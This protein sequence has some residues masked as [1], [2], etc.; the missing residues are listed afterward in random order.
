MVVV[1]AVFRP[2][3]GHDFVRYDD[4]MNIVQNPHV[5]ELTAANLY[6]MFTDTSYTRYMPL[7]WM[8]YAVDRQLFGLN[9]HAFHAGNLFFHLLNTLLLFSLL[10][11]IVLRATN[12]SE[13]VATCCAALGALWW[14]VNPLR[15]EPV[16]WA[17]ARIYN[18]AIF[19]ALVWL[20][21][22][23]LS[24]SAAS[25]TKRRLLAW[26]S[27]AGFGASLLTY[28]L[29]L[30]AP[31]A[32]F[33]MDVFPLRRGP[34]Q[35]RGW[36]RREA[37]PLWQEKIPFFCVSFIALATTAFARMGANT[38][39]RTLSL[40]DFGLLERAMQSCYVFAY[41]VWKPWAPLDLAAAYPT[42]HAFDPLGWRF[43]SSAVF[44]AGVTGAAIARR[45]RW[46]ILLP[47]WITHLVLLVPFLGLSEYP[48]SAFDRYAHLHSLL[49]TTVIAAA[50]A[51][52][53]ERKRV[54]A[55]SL[56][57]M[58]VACVAF[59]LLA[60]NQVP[61]WKNPV[62]LYTRIVERFGEHPGRSRFDEVLGTIH[63]Q[64]RRTNDAVA[65][66]ERAV[67]YETRR[68]DQNLYYESVAARSERSLA[69]I[70]SACG[71]MAGV[72]TH[73]QASLKF[74]R[75][76]ASIIGLSLRLSA[77]LSKLQRPA[78]A[79][80]WLR[81]AVEIVPND[82]RIHHELGTVYALN[83]NSAASE[84]HFTTERRLLDQRSADRSG[85]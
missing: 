16:S 9:P 30:T 37:W 14:A 42:L 59:A 80:P 70:S 60:M 20:W 36:F 1:F 12:K 43:V 83:G 6:W 52:G 46:P 73:L 31:I 44:L 84:Q 4:N 27:L 61:V 22:W 58:V 35:L 40:A 3:L 57:A 19:F 49:W 47:L 7:G 82:P 79:L 64:A 66:F 85:S 38:Q 71:D 5:S 23:L 24:R 54:R 34:S 51:A 69:E 33:A 17:S 29:A 10:K 21:T 65:A 28:P 18:V 63:Y 45:R 2:V 32:L 39:L 11:T 62:T 48:H 13:H 77:I 26:I 75:D 55:F 67:H 50:L 56:S 53:W 72:A 15:V 78:E 68:T 74:E 41:Y 76:P 25:E 8:C 81:K